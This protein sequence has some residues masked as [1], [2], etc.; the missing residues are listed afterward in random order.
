MDVCSS[1]LASVSITHVWSNMVRADRDAKEQNATACIFPLPLSLTRSRFSELR[2]ALRRD[3]PLP[4]R[5]QSESGRLSPKEIRK[6]ILDLVPEAATWVAPRSNGSKA[7]DFLVQSY[8]NGFPALPPA[9]S[10]HCSEGVRLI[11][12]AL[13]DPEGAGL[14]PARTRML[15]R[16]LAEAYTGCQAVQARTVDQL[17]G[18]VRGL[19]SRSLS[20]QLRV[21]VEE[22][23]EA[24][25]DRTVCHFHPG[26]PTAGDGTPH[27]QLPHLANL[28]RRHLGSVIGTSMSHM[29]AARSDRN[30]SGNLA[31]KKQVAEARFWYEFDMLELCRAV[32]A[33]VNQVSEETERRI[34]RRLLLDWAGSHQELG[35]RVFYD[36]SMPELYGDMMPS[37]DQQAMRQPFI[38]EDFACDLLLSVLAD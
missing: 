25:L 31:M 9:V 19:T 26:A 30:A 16:T 20:E 27:Q 2:D 28:Y 7:I 21:L 14:K 32:V 8:S 29:E 4:S 1:I 6:T 22:Y 13:A 5:P 23:R 17:Q 36:E 11:V 38:N 10:E 18:E 37:A 12:G 3:A 15:A 33:D 35:F 34:D 24:A